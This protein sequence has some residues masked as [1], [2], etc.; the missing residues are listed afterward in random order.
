MHSWGNYLFSA[1]ADIIVTDFTQA[2][3]LVFTVD[4]ISF[5]VDDS[6]LCNNAVLWRIH[7]DDLEFNRSHTTANRE[8]VALS[9]RSVRFEEVWFK[10]NIEE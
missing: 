2:L 3:L 5:T 4:W 7:L 1:A 8:Q 10:V 9:D 6:I